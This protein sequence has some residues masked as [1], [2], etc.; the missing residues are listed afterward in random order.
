[1][2]HVGDGDNG[3]FIKRV[4]NFVRQALTPEPKVDKIFNEAG[5]VIKETTT[6]YGVLW[7]V[8]SVFTAEYNEAG[9]ISNTENMEYDYA[10]RMTKY[11]KDKDGDNNNDYVATWEYNEAGKVIK[12]T[13]DTDGDGKDDVIANHEYNGDNKLTKSTVVEDVNGKHNRIETREYNG[14]KIINYTVDKNGDG[15]NEY[16]SNS[17]LNEAGQKIKNTFSAD[18]NSDGMPDYTLTTEYDEIGLAIKRTYTS[19]NSDGE[20]SVY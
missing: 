2:V 12:Y 8:N 14:A 17:E 7:K 9:Q 1:M 4:G 19:Y 6:N 10:G 15:N 11:S 13:V 16:T 18:I 3:K 5:Q 20:P